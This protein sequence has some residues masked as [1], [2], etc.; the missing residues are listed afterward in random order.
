M[1]LEENVYQASYAVP[2]EGHC[3]LDVKYGHQH[4]P[5]RLVDVYYTA[6]N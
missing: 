1:K 6:L 3:Q 4:V 5:K 2:E